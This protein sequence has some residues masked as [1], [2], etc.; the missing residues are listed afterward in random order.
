MTRH[1]DVLVVGAG[2]AG[3]SAATVAA[4]RGH[5][6]TLFDA[7]DRIGGQFNYAMRVPGT[8]EFAETLRYFKRRVEL[9]GVALVLN[10]KVT[11]EELLEQ[12]FDDVIV[13]TGIVPRMPGIDGIQHPK[14]LSYID[15]L[16]HNAPVGRRVAVVGAGGIGFDIG[17]FLLHDPHVPLPMPLNNWLGEWGV[18]L[19]ADS[20]GGLR[21]PTPEQPVRQVYLL[22]RKASKLGASLGKTSGWVHR[23]TLQRKGVKMIGGVDYR[24]IDDHGLHITVNGEPRILEVDNVVICAGQDS[25]KDLM[26]TQQNTAGPRFHLIGGAALAAELDAKRA[27]REGAEL[28]ARL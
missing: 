6:V 5:H 19:K 25:L 17:E 26:P 18:D 22:Q 8:E 24:K 11:R 14:V 4:E 3:L 10:K 13:A 7:S 9:T 16:K 27:I 2:P 20:N 15:V 1:L 21:A 23:A 28:A 12:G